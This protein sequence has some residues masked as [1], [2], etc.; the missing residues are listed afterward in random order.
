MKQRLFS[1]VFLAVVV[2]CW[3]ALATDDLQSVAGKWSVKKANEQGE[4]YTQ[5]LEVKNDKFVFQ[6][7]GA[8]DQTTLY[9]I[10][11]LKLER[12]GPFNSVRFFH[13]RA[14]GSAADLQDVDEEFVSIYV[15]DTDTWTMAA[16]FDKHRE[17]HKPS[18]DVYRRVTTSAPPKSNKPS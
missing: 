9:A 11:D 10:G 7:L 8:D 6:I 14:G 12:L 5:T 17:Q 3:S 15:L 2:S 4:K 16:N 13:I 1:T 18:T